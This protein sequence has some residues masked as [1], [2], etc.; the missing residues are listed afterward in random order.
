MIARRLPSAPSAPRKRPSVG[1]STELPPIAPLAASATVADAEL[2]SVAYALEV[3]PRFPGVHERRIA[4]AAFRAVT[5]VRQRYTD[6]EADN[7]LAR[8]CPVHHPSHGEGP[9][10]R[11]PTATLLSLARQYGLQGASLPADAPDEFD[12][13][14]AP[15]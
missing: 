4:R 1:G 7:V 15:F 3:S 12:E 13:D 5:T 9:T 8:L 6:P 11:S 14:P 10:L 2:A